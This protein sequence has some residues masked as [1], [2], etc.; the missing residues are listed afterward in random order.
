MRTSHLNS[1]LFWPS[2]SWICHTSPDCSAACIGL[3]STTLSKAPGVGMGVGSAAGSGVISAVGS[4][5]GS[6]F[7]SGVISAVGSTVG[8]AVGS[9]VISA[10]GSAVGSRGTSTTTS[11]VGSTVGSSVGSSVGSAVGSTVG[12]SVGS[13]VS[14]SAALIARRDM[15]LTEAVLAMAST[16]RVTV[17]KSW[18][19]GAS[20]LLS[21]VSM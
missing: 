5:V 2:S 15:V 20:T 13:M 16:V 14:G 1:T 9:G 10:V 11:I 3:I 19:Q 18:F 4:A 17:Q 6:A 7:G 8:S 12:S 21:K